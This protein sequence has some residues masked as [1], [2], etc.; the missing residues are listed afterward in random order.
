MNTSPVVVIEN[1]AFDYNGV[2]VLEGVNLTVNEREFVSL[3][4][5][6]G[7][8]KTT[9]LKLI[10]GLLRPTAGSVRVFGQA[11]AKARTRLGYMPQHLRFDPQFPV[12]V[13]DVVL[14][15]RLRAGLF[16]RYSAAD[17]EAARQALAEVD[18]PEL[19]ERSLAEL[20]GGERQRVLIARALASAPELLLLDEPTANV[21]ALMEEKLYELLLRLNQRLTIV[22]VSHD[23][24]FVSTLVKSVV[25]VN[26]TVAVHPTSEMTGHNIRDI[27]SGE[28]AMIRHDHRCAEDGH[29]H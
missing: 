24:G 4:G 25:C 2:T 11:P 6:N 9:L 17:K 18:L 27:Y 19:G 7:G 20:S 29:R 10:L 1:L 5:P 23:I 13:M 3:V 15:G 12:T 28:V 16:G 21:D 14:M 26:R 22:L 8:G